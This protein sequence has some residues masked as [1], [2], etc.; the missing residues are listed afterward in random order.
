MDIFIV[1]CII[2]GIVAGVLIRDKKFFKVSSKVLL[3]LMIILIFLIGFNIGNNKSLIASLGE[4]GFI[5]VGFAVICAFFSF[6]LTVLIFLF[7]N[8]KK[9]GGR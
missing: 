8:K 3:A 1:I 9:G 6:I 7:I 4:I 5:S 2:L